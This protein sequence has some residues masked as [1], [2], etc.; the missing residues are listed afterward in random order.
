MSE[1]LDLVRSL[2]AEWARG[3]YRSA[4]WAH[5]ELEYTNV[6]GPYRGTRVGL[7]EMAA[8]WRLLL[9]AWSEFSTNADEYDE[10]ADGRVLARATLAGA[11]RFLGLL[12]SAGRAPGD[13]AFHIEAGKVL[14][15]T[16]YW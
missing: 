2:Y 1:N 15:F 5:P 8:G 11:A 3:R 13:H 9:S 6:D 16:P 14:P 10:L 7:T 12:I 4:E